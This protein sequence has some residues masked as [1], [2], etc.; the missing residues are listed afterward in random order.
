M[1]ITWLDGILL[2]LMFISAILAMVRGF[3][4]EVLSITSWVAAVVAVFVLFKSVYPF[5]LEQ[6][7]DKTIA[8]AATVGGVFL[9]TLLLVSLITIKI[10]DLVLDSK[11]G[12]LDRTLGFVF[13]SA[14]GFLLMTIAMIFVN[15]LVP[16]DGRPGWI[17]D[18]KSKPALDTAAEEIITLLPDDPE[19]FNTWID[20]LKNVFAE[21]SGDQASRT[22]T[23]EPARYS[24]ASRGQLD[25]LVASDA[26]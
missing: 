10:S 19:L 14:R 7:S 18:A 12:P 23:D 17:E 26:Q 13:G 25:Q 21:E 15:W 5:A 22:I 24:D 11:I 2:G 4:R 6:I 20:A 1:P 8:A 3:M 16:S 9:V